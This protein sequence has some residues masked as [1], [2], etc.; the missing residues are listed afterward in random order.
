M[1]LG[2]A[3]VGMATDVT[4]VGVGTGHLDIDAKEYVGSKLGCHHS[5]DAWGSF[6]TDV[7]FSSPGS[8]LVMDIQQA[9]SSSYASFEAVW[10][11]DFVVTNKD[12]LCKRAGVFGLYAEGEDG[13]SMNQQSN[14]LRNNKIKLISGEAISAEGD[15]PLYVGGPA[16]TVENWMHFYDSYS[17]IGTNPP[18]D[19]SFTGVAG[20]GGTATMEF[21]GDPD[22]SMI[23]GYRNPVPAPG[24]HGRGVLFS[25]AV[26]VDAGIGTY[27]R[28]VCGHQYLAFEGYTTPGGGSW[29]GSGTFNG[30]MT[31][32]PW[33]TTTPITP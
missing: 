6:V 1:V 15:T 25:S 13:A 27:T 29:S 33:T 21:H 11:Q 18:L 23:R 32:D 12:P 30:G 31:A 20:I 19:W 14:A 26:D 17:D 28:D 24:D 2:L 4:I 3:T 9:K 22:S 8:Y 10:R 7:D 16:Y 5:F